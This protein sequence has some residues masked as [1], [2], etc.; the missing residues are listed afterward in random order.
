MRSVIDRDVVMRRTTVLRL[1]KLLY[2]RTTRFVERRAA[3]SPAR[4]KNFLFFW[5][6]LRESTKAFGAK[7]VTSWPKFKSMYSRTEIMKIIHAML[8]FDVNWP[9][10]REVIIFVFS[11]LQFQHKTYAFFRS[12]WCIDRR[13]DSSLCV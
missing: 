6:N 10:L 5:E 12:A 9:A 13:P 8:T 1:I 3:G 7:Y 4:D 11:A 2:S